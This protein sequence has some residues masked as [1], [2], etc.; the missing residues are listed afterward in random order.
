MQ[1]LLLLL[2]LLLTELGASRRSLLRHCVS[3]WEVPGSIPGRVLEHFQLTY[4]F[5]PQSVILGSTQPLTDTNT[6][7]FPW[8]QITAS[9]L[10]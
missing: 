2:L 8:G 1:L 4:S 9:V 5:C 10:N 3:R 6:D 7:E